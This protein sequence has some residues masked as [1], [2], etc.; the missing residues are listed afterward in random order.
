MSTGSYSFDIYTKGNINL[1]VP[2][3]LMASYLYYV[4]D[5]SLMQDYEFDEMC[6]VMLEKWGD[7]DHMHKYLISESSLRCGTGFNIKD[8]PLMVV[9]ASHQIARDWALL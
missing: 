1:T 5:V 8:Y 4:K 9:G 6:K 7:I 2:W 3:Y